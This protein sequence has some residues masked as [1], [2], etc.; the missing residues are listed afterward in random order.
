[1]L[2]L[3]LAAD[4]GTGLELPPGNDEPSSVML[5][6]EDGQTLEADGS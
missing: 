5:E 2:G 4:V 1:V 3:L 6:G